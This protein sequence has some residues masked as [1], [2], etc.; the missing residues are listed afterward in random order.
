V[1]WICGVILVYSILFG[2]GK[3]ILGEMLLGVGLLGLGLLAGGIMYWDLS[4]RG[5]GEVTGE[6]SEDH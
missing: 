3:F 1:D 2:V 5:W 4:R 6:G